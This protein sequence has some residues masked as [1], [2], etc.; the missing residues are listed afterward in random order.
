MRAT[1][2]GPNRL[3]TEATDTSAE[4]SRGPPRR[5]VVTNKGYLMTSLPA[6]RWPS[7]FSTTK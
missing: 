1:S 3:A 6:T 4:A 2:D 7:Q 5:T